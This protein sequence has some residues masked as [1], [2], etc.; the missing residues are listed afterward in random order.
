MGHLFNK[1]FAIATV[2]L[3]SIN[4][5]AKAQDVSA[6]VPPVLISTYAKAEDTPV[7]L[8]SP[9]FVISGGFGYT[10]LKGNELVYDSGNRISHLIWETKAPVVTLNAK[11]EIYND[12]TI[13]GNAVFGFNGD[14]HMVDYDWLAG[15]YAFDNWTDRSIHPDTRLDKYINLDVALGRNFTLNDAVIVNLH[16]GLKY[17][18]VK[19]TAYG[20]SFVYSQTGFRKDI[21]N[22]AADQKGISFEQR[23]PGIFIGT[24]AKINHAQWTLRGLARAGV[25]IGATDTDHHWVRDLRFEEKYGPIPFMSLGAEAGYQVTDNTQFTLG[26]NFE[27]FFRKKG[28]TLIYDIPS[29][30]QVAGPF[31]DGAGMDFR[32]ITLSAG[33]KL[34]F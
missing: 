16:G 33:L 1:S 24:E 32:S 26:A 3:V 19:S 9:D 5:L 28:D 2:A 15:D 23:Y 10:W 11:G 34:A 8:A 31:K 7:G 27:Q 22:F 17:T 12:W 6:T 14:S 25:T 13:S 30:R 18:N 29:G 20:G 4:T 21:G